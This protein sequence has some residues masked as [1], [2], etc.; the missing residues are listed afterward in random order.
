MNTASVPPRLPLVL[1]ADVGRAELAIQVTAKSC[2]PHVRS[3]SQRPYEL[4]VYVSVNGAEPIF[5]APPVDTSA[6]ASM[7]EVIAATCAGT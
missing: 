6:Q 2:D 5:V 3:Q 1:P 7:Q 4:S